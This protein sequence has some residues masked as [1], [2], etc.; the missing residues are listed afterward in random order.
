MSLS[1]RALIVAA[2]LILLG[3][4]GAL[5]KPYGTLLPLDVSDLSE[6]Q[7]QLDRLD[8]EERELVLG[9]LRRSNGDVLPASLADPDAPFTART[10]GE[11]IALQRR[12]LREQGE[13]DAVAAQRAAERESA[14]QPLRE[15]LDLRLLRRELL[16]EAEALGLQPAAAPSQAPTSNERV[17]VVT[18][19]L[20]NASGRDITRASGSAR[21]RDAAGRQR[22]DCWLQQERLPAFESVEVRCGN[23]AR[24]ADA[25]QRAFVAL[26]VSE[27]RLEWEPREI[28]FGDGSRLAAPH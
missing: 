23:T 3:L 25:D 26:P 5:R 28:V 15:A 8:A 7:P 9:Y 20:I 17:L 22:S 27:L 10:F 1:T 18:Y 13:R 4:Y 16:S 11:A 19:R 2:L 6:I 12:Y 14:L 24:R 21:V